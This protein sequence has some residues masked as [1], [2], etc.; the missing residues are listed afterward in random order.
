MIC[1]KEE[2]LNAGKILISVFEGN[3]V[4]VNDV[5]ANGNDRITS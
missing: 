2:Y 5:N 3:D 1:Y 4:N